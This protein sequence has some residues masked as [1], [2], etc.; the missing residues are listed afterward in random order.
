MRIYARYEADRGK[1]EKLELPQINN[2]YLI[3][4]GFKIVFVVIIFNW[5][6]IISED[7]NFRNVF[8]YGWHLICFYFSREH[9]NGYICAYGFFLLSSEV[10]NICKA[11]STEN[12]SFIL[13]SRIHF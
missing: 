13:Y 9:C 10:R 5:M 11:T 1:R 12:S 2:F 7:H 4:L 6:H 8:F 3:Y